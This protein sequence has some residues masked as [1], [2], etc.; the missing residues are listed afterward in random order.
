[1]KD[2]FEKFTSVPDWIYS[3]IAGAS[4]IL[5]ALVW[6]SGVVGQIFSSNPSRVAA[7]DCQVGAPLNTCSTDKGSGHTY[8]KW[9]E[10]GNV[11]GACS[12]EVCNNGGTPPDCAGGPSQGFPC[13]SNPSL[14]SSVNQQYCENMGLGSAIIWKHGGACDPNNGEH[15]S[16][17]CIFL[18]D[19]V[20]S[21][22]G[23]N[24]TEGGA[25]AVTPTPSNLGTCFICDNGDWRVA[26]GSG[27]Q[28][29]SEQCS[30]EQNS[31]FNQ[32]N[33][34]SWCAAA[35]EATPTPTP[36]SVPGPTATPTPTLP[37]GVTPTPT[38]IIPTPS[39][40]AV[41]CSPGQVMTVSG[42]QVICLNVQQQQSQTAT[43]GSSSST[44]SATGGGGGSSTVN[45][46]GAAAPVSV[47]RVAGA[48]PGVTVSELPKTGLPIAGWLLSGLLPAGLGLK[49]FG[50]GRTNLKDGSSYIWQKRRFEKD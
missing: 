36:T 30:Q 20:R 17:G 42:S 49:S 19:N 1:M 21:F 22:T 13:N 40:A 24:C 18:F 15:D 32:P 26:G 34:P 7:L 44:S 6:Q 35:A 31:A 41:V 28:M 14:C 3:G 23:P 39:G 29:T 38:V 50:R 45:I 11:E 2:L 33:K 43:G 27:H 16:N 10:D 5:L 48:A 25:P 12:V 9:T 4:L 47:V 8:C 37:P 46:T